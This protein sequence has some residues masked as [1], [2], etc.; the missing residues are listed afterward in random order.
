M[1]RQTREEDDEE[2]KKEEKER[3]WGAYEQRP[4]NGAN[5]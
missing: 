1:K 3:C 2:E 4:N 5:K